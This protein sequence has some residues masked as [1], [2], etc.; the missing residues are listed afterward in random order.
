MSTFKDWLANNGCVYDARKKKND[1]TG[2]YAMTHTF[3]DGGC[4]A[5]LEDDKALVQ[6]FYDVFAKGVIKGEHISISEFRTETFRYFLDFDI[7]ENEELTKEEFRIIAQYLMEAISLVLDVKI[8]CYCFVSTREAKKLDNGII[9]SGFH[10]NFPLLKVNT[11]IARKLRQIIIQY[12]ETKDDIKQLEWGEVIDECVYTTAG[13]RMIGADKAAP[14]PIKNCAGNKKKID[15]IKDH[16]KNA[17]AYCFVCKN[18]GRVY[19]NRRYY[20]YLILKNDGSEYVSKMKKCKL[21]DEE[22]LQDYKLLSFIIKKNSIRATGDVNVKWKETLPAWY[23]PRPINEKVFKKKNPPKYLD[24]A[25][26]AEENAMHIKGYSEL[27][28]IDASDP[29]FIE[30]QKFIQQ[31]WSVYNDLRIRLFKKSG[32][33]NAKHYSYQIQTYNHYCHN[34]GREHQSQHIWFHID[35]QT[36][37]IHQRCFDCKD[38]MS[39]H[40]I[41]LSQKMVRLLFPEQY[42]KVESQ[43]QLIEAKLQERQKEVNDFETLFDIDDLE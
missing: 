17:N 9:K 39:K 31:T 5:L 14:C 28:R 40:F 25:E 27:E 7:K 30:L 41:K 21:Y 36:H 4:V 8:E 42:E 13:L 37:A 43:R 22:F 11:F 38:Y 29:R 24:D 33:R 32:K 19:D 16:E 26:L 18:F 6:N 1:K 3:M 20:P 35:P 34:I 2:T 23:K 10:V 12:L 15:N